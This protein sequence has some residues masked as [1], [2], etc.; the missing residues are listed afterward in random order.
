MSRKIEGHPFGSQSSRF[1]L[2]GVHPNRL[3]TGKMPY[4]ENLDAQIV[5]IL[6][7]IV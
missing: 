7:F 2:S 6:F 5:E 4:Q 3:A 1:N